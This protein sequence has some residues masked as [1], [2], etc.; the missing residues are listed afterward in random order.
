MLYWHRLLGLVLTDYF[1]GSRYHVEMETDLSLKEQILDL[2]IIEQ[3]SGA[4]VTE[5]PD[6]LENLGPHNLLTYK[7]LR[8]PLDEWAMDELV[9]HY[10]N[11]R[12]QKSPSLRELLPTEDFSLY[13][14]CTRQP[15]KLGKG[16][17]LRPIKKGVHEVQWG[18]KRIRIIVLNQVAKTKRNALWQLFSGAKERVAY[19]ATNYQWRSNELSKS[20]NT[21][22][23]YYRLE[24][25][26][27]PYT[28]EDFEREYAE[29]FLARLTPE[30]IM[31]WMPPEDFVKKFPPEEIIKN[32]PPE[33]RLKGLP[34]EVRLKG[35]RPEERLKGL[36][37]EELLKRLTKEQIEAY[38]KKLEPVN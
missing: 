12:K 37:P 21:L 23:D 38:L 9:G 14:V 30:K 25:I 11:Y 4:S 10:V 7:S 27:M 26:R 8:Q 5:F 17:S 19:G 20:I 34:P 24:G 29:G 33:E 13:A 6:G 36:P 1:T 32:L 28:V 22:F 31:K 35:L 3:E 2:L 16:V 18:S 15:I